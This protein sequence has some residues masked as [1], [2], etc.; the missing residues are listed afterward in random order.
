MKH[1]MKMAYINNRAWLSLHS[2]PW[3]LHRTMVLDGTKTLRTVPN[4]DHRIM[5][6]E[7]KLSILLSFMDWPKTYSQKCL[8]CNYIGV[9]RSED[10]SLVRGDPFSG[11]SSRW[12]AFG[13]ANT[14]YFLWN[15][16]LHDSD[17]NTP[18]IKVFLQR[19]CQEPEV[20]IWELCLPTHKGNKSW[21]PSLHL[22]EALDLGLCSLIFPRMPAQN[23]ERSRV[24]DRLKPNLHIWR[25]GRTKEI[26]VILTLCNQRAVDSLKHHFSYVSIV[27][28]QN[29]LQG[30]DGH[31]T[32]QAQMYKIETTQT[33]VL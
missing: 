28:P 15:G 9:F 5:S 23:L 22:G 33:F 31:F 4:C 1:P 30:Y 7:F 32:P 24:K 20:R 21:G 11:S 2:F 12:S 3:F 10:T 29:P 8:L 19:L 13:I 25:M 27:T 6:N 26:I 18:Q 17:G 16:P 14:P